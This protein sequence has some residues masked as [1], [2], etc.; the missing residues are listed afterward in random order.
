MVDVIDL[1]QSIKN[2]FNEKAKVIL[3][4]SYYNDL[5]KKK[6][7]DIASRYQCNYISV[8]NKGYGYGNNIGIKFARDNYKFDF[9]AVC[10]PDTTIKKFNEEDF[11][12]PNEPAIYAPKIIAHDG[13][14]QNPNWAFHN[15]ILENLQYKSCKNELVLLDYFVIAILKSERYLYSLWCK[16]F[17]RK[18]AKI[19]SAHGSFVILS[20]SAIDR[21]APLYDEH[22]FLFYEEMCLA[23]KAL[24]KRVPTY[25]IKDTIILHK[26]D[27]SMKLSSIS[28][29]KEAHKSVEY[30]HEYIKQSK[31]YDAHE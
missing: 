9:L 11:L 10:N 31:V 5:T 1:I 17:N 20:R 6:A 29:K 4:E 30:Y 18:R 12:E 21:L 27:G 28:T 19:Y 8:K 23:Y 15:E 3:V 7:K 16:I 25:Y 24:Q 22:I 2:N 13:K 26:E 14:I